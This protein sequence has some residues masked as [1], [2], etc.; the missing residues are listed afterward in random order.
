MPV[1]KLYPVLL[2]LKP[3]MPDLKFFTCLRSGV[4][5]DLN[6][7]E[8]NRQFIKCCP[9]AFLHIGIDRF[10]RIAFVPAGINRLDG[11]CNRRFTLVFS[12]TEAIKN[13]FG[14]KLF[15]R[16]TTSLSTMKRSKS[17]LPSVITGAIHRK[18]ISTIGK[19]CPQF[20]FVQIIGKAMTFQQ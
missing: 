15:R 13:F 14:Q 17:L 16:T 5:N 2:S 19:T 1:I 3:G 9:E 11:Q 4:L 8:V 12:K 18:A 6:V 20:P 7:A 10:K